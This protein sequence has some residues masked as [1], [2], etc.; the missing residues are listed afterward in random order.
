M[1]ARTPLEKLLWNLLGAPLYYCEDCLKHV[2]VKV[3]GDDVAIKRFCAHTDARIIAP[4]K[5]TVTGKGFAGLT[6]LQKL[7][8]KLQQSGAALTGR[9]V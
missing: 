3:I 6:P 1:D 4:R 9:N 8:V 7:K 2:N 5:A